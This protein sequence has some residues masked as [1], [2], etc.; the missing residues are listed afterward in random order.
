MMIE[1]SATDRH[2]LVR[3]YLDDTTRATFTGPSATQGWQDFPKYQTEI[4][5]VPY[6]GAFVYAVKRYVHLKVD[7]SYDITEDANKMMNQDP[8][9]RGSHLFTNGDDGGD[10]KHY[11]YDLGSTYNSN[12]NRVIAM[13]FAFDSLWMVF[14]P[15]E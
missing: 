15:R 8:C 1:Y 4:Q 5:F 6:W 9:L 13:E 14:S 7:A 2:K 10:L 11:R 12:D 3:S